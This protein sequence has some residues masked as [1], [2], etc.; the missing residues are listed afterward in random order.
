MSSENL[1]SNSASN[2]FEP[3]LCKNH[4]PN[5]PFYI[6]FQDFNAF[7]DGNTENNQVPR[8]FSQNNPLIKPPTTDGLSHRWSQGD[9]P[10]LKYT[11]RENS[12]STSEIPIYQQYWRA[13]THRTQDPMNI[14]ESLSSNAT[15]MLHIRTPI[16][17]DEL[18]E[19]GIENTEEGEYGSISGASSS[20]RC[21]VGVYSQ[22]S[23]Q[24]DPFHHVY[25]DNS[26]PSAESIGI[27]H[28]C[29]KPRN[30]TYDSQMKSEQVSTTFHTI[31][32]IIICTISI[33]HQKMFYKFKL[34]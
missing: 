8:Q 7:R 11:P 14:P 3:N 1:V 17:D 26:S 29:E 28:Y 31:S 2:P 13:H 20:D 18:G 19:D 30:M 34:R 32:Y 10:A 4:Q 25:N 23:I 22:N 5:M 33:T 6:D 16:R 21:G 24:N 9:H 27:R 12:P 15:R